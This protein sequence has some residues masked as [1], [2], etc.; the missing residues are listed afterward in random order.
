MALSEEVI[1]GTVLRC[2]SRVGAFASV[3]TCLCHVVVLPL[4]CNCLCL[5][6]LSS[7]SDW[8]LHLGLLF[9]PVLVVL[10]VVLGSFLIARDLACLAKGLGRLF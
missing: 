1:R 4:S 6:G 8:R 9:V 2:A 10:R 3:A 5:L 7:Y